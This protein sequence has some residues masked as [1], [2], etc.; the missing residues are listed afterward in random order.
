MKTTTAYTHYTAHS[1]LTGEPIRRLTAEESARYREEAG[2]SEDC[3]E[4]ADSGVVD[5]DNYDIAESF[6][7]VEVQS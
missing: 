7:G 1:Y 2:I 6:Y 4:G 3:H 5:G